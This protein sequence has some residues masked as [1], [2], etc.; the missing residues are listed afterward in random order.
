MLRRVLAVNVE[1]APGRVARMAPSVSMQRAGKPEAAAALRLMG[2][3]AAYV[4]GAVL[5]VGDGR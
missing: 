4:T 5:P 2:T 3:A 1:S